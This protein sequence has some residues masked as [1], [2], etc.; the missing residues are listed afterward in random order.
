MSELLESLTE[1]EIN[2]LVWNDIMGFNGSS[3]Y[4]FT[5]GHTRDG[6]SGATSILQ[7][8]I[9]SMGISIDADTWNGKEFCI[10]CLIATGAL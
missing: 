7:N 10:E 1:E 4:D 6:I 9:N 3:R 8:K 2:N 5:Y